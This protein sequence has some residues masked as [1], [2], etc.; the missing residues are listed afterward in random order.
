MYTVFKVENAIVHSDFFLQWLSTHEANQRIKNSAQGSVRE[1]VSFSDLGAIPFTIPPM[2][3]QKKTISVLNTA[4][5]EI[6]ALGRK[7]E[8]LREQKRFLLNNLVT[9]TIRLSQFVGSHVAKV[10]TGDTE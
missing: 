5:A 6:V 2:A 10:T 7:L 3:T 9:G 4:D 8:A 1:T